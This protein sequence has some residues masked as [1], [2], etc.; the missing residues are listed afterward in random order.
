MIR[1]YKLIGVL[2]ILTISVRLAGQ[3]DAQYISKLKK[4]VETGVEDRAKMAQVMVDKVFSYAELGFQE[5]ETSNYLTSILKENGFEIEFGIS[6]VPTAWWAK[7]GNGKPVIA[8]GSDL[9]CI[10]KASQRPGVAYHDPIVEGAPGHGEGHN[11]GTPLKYGEAVARRFYKIQ[12][13][14]NVFTDQ[15]P[16]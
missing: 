16:F 11:S 3:A 15:L 10:P 14:P 13:R 8:L 12:P 6:G 2:I 9:D 5:V 1:M 7:W 4:A